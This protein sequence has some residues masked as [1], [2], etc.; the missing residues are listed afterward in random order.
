MRTLNRMIIMTV[1]VLIASCGTTSDV[2]IPDNVILDGG[3]EP[4]EPNSSSVLVAYGQY[5]SIPKYNL[6][7]GLIEIPNDPGGGYVS[8][9][10]LSENQ[11]VCP[12]LDVISD[13]DDGNGHIIKRGVD[14]GTFYSTAYFSVHPGMTYSLGTKFWMQTRP[15]NVRV[16]MPVKY[17]ILWKF[18][19]R[20]DCFEPNDDQS[21]AKLI[22]LDETVEAYAIAGYIDNGIRAGDPQTFDWYKV[23]LDNAGILEAKALQ[24]PGDGQ[25]TMKLYNE[26][27]RVHTTTKWLGPDREYDN[28]NRGRL[29]KV[30][31]SETVPAG[32][33]Y[34]ETHFA[35]TKR[36]AHIQSNDPIPDHFNKTYKIMVTKK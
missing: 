34:I 2:P 22:P 27:G 23:E 13:Q 7:E 20:V 31:S 17:R 3:C 1:A 18:N 16:S 36:K 32:T 12:W 15:H 28:I 33:Y 10:V 25:L 6:H 24:V 19:S 14:P 35:Y 21:Q 5:D 29:S 8:V 30:T 26:D 11:R 4:Y 9:Q